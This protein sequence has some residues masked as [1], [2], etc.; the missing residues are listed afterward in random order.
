MPRQK[1]EFQCTECHKI[2]DINL[3]VALN[4]N[5]RIHCPNCGHVHYRE[6]KKGAI[7][8]TRF[9]DNHESILVEDI[10]PMKA[11][12]RDFKKTVPE[13]VMYCVQKPEDAPGAAM[14]FLRRLW[15]E[16]FSARVEA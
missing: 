13:D 15:L 1:F 14:G 16:K 7:T 11:S 6:I 5:Y 12:C 3:N 10:Y 2:F 8:D 9:P 4:G